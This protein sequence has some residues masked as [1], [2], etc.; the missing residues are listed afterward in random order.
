MAA[1]DR[2]LKSLLKASLALPGIASGSGVLD[3][4]PVTYKHLSYQED[5][6]MA[7]E[8]DYFSLG[9]PINERSDLTISLEYEN[10]AGASPIFNLRGPDDEVIQVTSGASIT[11][12]R[13]AVAVN[14]RRFEDASVLS[15]TPAIS[16]ENDYDSF[17]TTLEYQWDRN[18]K[19]TTFSFGAGLS[20][21]DIGATGQNLNENKMSGS[22]FGGITQVLNAQS[23]LQ[24][25]LS[26]AQESGYLSD[27][28]KLALVETSFVPDNR[29]DER[30][31]TAVLI[32][33]IAYRESDDASL[34]LGYRYFE[35][36]WGTESHTLE[37]S[38][39]REFSNGW[40]ASYSFRYYSQE[41]AEFYAPF[42]NSTRADGIYSSD[43]R[44]AGYG[45]IL[46]GLKLDKSF[47]QDTSI[48]LNLELYT[49][50]SDLKFGGDESDYADPLESYLVSFGF[51]HS[52]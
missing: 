9:I 2:Y 5:E 19:N 34:H 15:L 14:Y 27:P 29:P 21:D 17:A 41:Q 11:D 46:V 39:N 51:S 44:L 49:R 52:F 7:V 35:D 42:Y 12:E 31:Q 47:D 48:N 33:Y 24:L 32:R 20:N 6:L 26:L 16:T 22:L 28:Y 50:R 37:T 8:A 43:Y 18:E 30:L 45:S 1:T 10:M 25:N 36:D 23:L 4:V 3:D 38:W 13:T 40:L